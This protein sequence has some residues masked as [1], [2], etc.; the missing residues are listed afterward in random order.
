ML[1]R[2]RLEQ[3]DAGKTLQQA[4]LPRAAHVRRYPAS[5]S[6]RHLGDD[7]AL[8]ATVLRRLA[9]PS[10]HT[11]A[12][13]DFRR[14]PR[15]G[16]GGEE[17]SEVDEDGRHDHRASVRQ[18]AAVSCRR[19]VDG[20]PRR[21]ALDL[22]PADVLPDAHVQLNVQPRRVPVSYPRVPHGLQETRSVSPWRPDMTFGVQSKGIQ[23]I[24][25]NNLLHILL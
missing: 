1:P 14:P 16:G 20:R 15:Q 21:P 3:A 13:T 23:D 10:R 25:N 12:R 22:R 11:R 18:L 24:G 19:S 2:V 9:A 4:R 6:S 17:G 7:G 8:R 5:G